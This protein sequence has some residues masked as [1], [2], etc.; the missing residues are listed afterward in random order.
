MDEVAVDKEFGNVV[1]KINPDYYRP[2]G[3]ECLV[4]DCTKAKSE[5]KWEPEYT[6]EALVEE[7]CQYDLE[8]SK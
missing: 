5:L 4:G 8:V 7:M 1:V 2:I 3:K 6:F